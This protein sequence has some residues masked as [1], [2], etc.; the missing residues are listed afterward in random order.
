MISVYFYLISFEWTVGDS[1]SKDNKQRNK[2]IFGI[3][4]CI[5]GLLLFSV[6]VYTAIL[7]GLHPWLTPALPA[8]ARP[9]LHTFNWLQ[10]EL[11]GMCGGCLMLL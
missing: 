9:F 10:E 6:F 3:S 1:I 5:P 11:G 7:K 2:M 8:T 4:S